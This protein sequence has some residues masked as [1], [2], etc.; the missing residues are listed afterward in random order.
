MIII[1]VVLFLVLRKKD[2]SPPTPPGPDPD[3][4]HYNPYEVVTSDPV[5]M[6]YKLAL[7]PKE[8][9]KFKF[10][11]N[12]TF[13]NKQFTTITLQGQNS[14]SAGKTL[15]FS[16]QGGNNVTV[17]KSRSVPSNAAQPQLNLSVDVS[18]QFNINVTDKNTKE[19]ILTTMNQSFI[20]MEHF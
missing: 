11:Y 7:N 9:G 6:T 15:R 19:V 4:P 12:E 13:N 3:I 16:F 5:A 18:T 10:P 2:P 17:H 8:K 20:M 14:F 1:G